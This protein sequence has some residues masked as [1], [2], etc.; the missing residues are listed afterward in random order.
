METANAAA[1]ILLPLLALLVILN[2][3]RAKRGRELFI[4][5]LPG[6]D[7]IEEVVGRA[8]ELGRP[9][10]F[11]IGLG[12]VDITTLQA[13]S[14]IGHVTQLAAR[15]RTRVIVPTVSAMLIPVI[16]EVQREAHVAVGAEEA[17]NAQD[18]RFLSDAQFAYAAGVVGLMHR[19]QVGAN[20][21]FGTFAA[22]S[23]VMAENGQAVGAVQIA[24]TPDSNQIPFFLATCDYTILGE[25]YYATTALL[26]RE[27]VL[28][29]SLV[30]QD[31]VKLTLLVLI[32]LGL[33]LTLVQGE[34]ANLLAQFLKPGGA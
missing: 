23:L 24:A 17:F 7:A 12:G 3:Q 16:E 33:L 26:S 31:Y 18:I 6:I 29:G 5:R 9:V 30:G 21:F 25:E 13:V 11:S 2:I 15:F 1:R 32:V 28:T 22:E 4:R 34:E 20:F 10:L 19:E 8:V 14:V 27:P